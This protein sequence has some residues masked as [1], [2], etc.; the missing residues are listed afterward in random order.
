M[1]TTE[2]QQAGK[3]QSLADE[4][5]VQIRDLNLALKLNPEE[6]NSKLLQQ[7]ALLIERLEELEPD[8][9]HLDFSTDVDPRL[10]PSSPQF[11]IELY[12]AS[13]AS[14]DWD[15]LRSRLE[16]TQIKIT[17][18]I[19]R[20]LSSAEYV[21]LRETVSDA[22]QDIIRSVN[23]LPNMD[24]LIEEV[25]LRITK[26]LESMTPEAWEALQAEE[27]AKDEDQITLPE[28]EAQKAPDHAADPLQKLV[29]KVTE[30]A[31]QG[32]I[33]QGTATNTLTKIKPSSKNTSIDPVT[34]TATITRGSM[35]VVIPNYDSISG[36]KTSTYQLLDFFTR[37]LTEG[38]AKSPIVT[39][40]L[41]EYMEKRGLKD[42]KEARKQVMDDLETLFNAK[43][44][45][46]EKRGKEEQ[47]FLDMRICDS[48]GINRKGDI[49]FSFGSTFFALL[50]GYPIMP[51]PEQ[52][53]RLNSK[54]NPN[55][56]ALLRKIAEH[57][58]M[59]A[60]KKNENIIAVSTL[61]SACESI[62]DYESV[63]QSANN[64]HVTERIIEP[65]ER[66]MNAL[67][68]TLTW[69]YCHRNGSPLTEEELA[70]FDYRIFSESLIYTHWK[71]YPD[72]TKRLEKKAQKIEDAKKAKSKRRKREKPAPEKGGETAHK[73][74]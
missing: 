63:K 35:T 2:K 54:R 46:K 33:R 64:R 37:A 10:N 42:R 6:D 16:E 34:H 48:K 52:L 74:G 32:Y 57:K 13:L 12:R 51:Y 7:R 21:T 56:Y 50:K 5:R 59:N 29:E 65:F 61:L 40:P 55:S 39:L 25:I 60:G 4:I 9:I 68:E 23:A 66:D 28:F 18:K 45:F 53:L 36:L 26:A 3:E 70:Q 49:T 17:K 8:T 15:S 67:E 22:E 47:A 73:G 58:N 31:L 14:I 24:G 41:S 20:F 44:S 30:E 71:D 38:G 62:P 43:I 69:E 72:Q 11:D 19:E 1:N 27:A